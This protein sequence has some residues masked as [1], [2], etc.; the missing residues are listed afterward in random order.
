MHALLLFL[1]V[2]D[3][4]NVV[5]RMTVPT[6][7]SYVRTGYRPKAIFSKNVYNIIKMEAKEHLFCVT[8]DRPGCMIA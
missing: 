8:F 6:P 1:P 4:R 2:A 7:T 3:T 5:V